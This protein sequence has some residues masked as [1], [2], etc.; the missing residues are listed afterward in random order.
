[1]KKTFPNF[2]TLDEIKCLE[3]LYPWTKVNFIDEWIS[4]LIKPSINCVWWYRIWWWKIETIKH[5]INAIISM[6]EEKKN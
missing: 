1:M 2:D 5:S 3:T 4:L 6:I